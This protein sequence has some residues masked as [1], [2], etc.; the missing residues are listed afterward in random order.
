MSASKLQVPASQLTPKLLKIAND[1]VHLML[2]RRLESILDI[3]AELPAKETYDI[4]FLEH[5]LE[6]Y[7]GDWLIV[8]VHKGPRMREA[9]FN[10]FEDSSSKPKYALLGPD[11]AARRIQQYAPD[12]APTDVVHGFPE[13]YDRYL[14]RRVPS[15]VAEFRDRLELLS[16]RERQ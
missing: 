10:I 9:R 6:P 13:I 12:L 7:H 16:M 8:D 5:C 2:K 1:A 3:C 4:R 11:S 14:R 15:R